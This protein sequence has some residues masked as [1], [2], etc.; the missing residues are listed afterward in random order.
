MT[1]DEDDEDDEE[2]DLG[3]LAFAFLLLA[4]AAAADVALVILAMMFDDGPLAHVD[5]ALSLSLVHVN[6]RVSPRLPPPP[7]VLF[8]LLRFGEP[9]RAGFLS[10]FSPAAAA[11][12]ASASSPEA[13]FFVSP[14]RLNGTR[15]RRR[16]TDRGADERRRPG[17][18]FR[19]VG[20]GRRMREVTRNDNIAPTSATFGPT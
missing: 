4:P 11:A 18:R 5:G 20:V 9:G 19:Q 6:F 1:P 17:G 13:R 12:T 8:L 2:T 16:R 7:F 10:T 15:L 14:C 3:F